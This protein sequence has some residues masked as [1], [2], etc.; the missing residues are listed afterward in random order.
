MDDIPYQEAVGSLLYLAQ[1]TRPDI[2][3]AVND[4]SRFNNKHGKAHWAAVKRIFRYLRGTVDY[5][6]FYGKGEELKGYTDADWASDIDKRRSCSGYVFTM[7]GGAI[8]WNS[9]R[10]P[11]VALSTAEA[12]YLS[13]SAA[14][15]EV[16]WLR[17]FAA[18][19]DPSLITGPKVIACL[20]NGI[21]E[22]V[23]LQTE[24]MVA[25]TLT[26]AVPSSKHIFCCEGM[27]LKS[28]SD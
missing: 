22:L 8:S 1:G 11:T 10:Q 4:V 3:F 5:K 19:V 14:V 26:K 12:E 21:I 28:N 25:D 2:A 18:E 15:Q 24:F 6:L 16:K 27:G 23:Y 9:K 17:Q 7:C 20:Q 13:V